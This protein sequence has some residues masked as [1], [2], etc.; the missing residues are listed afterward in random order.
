MIEVIKTSI[1]FEG[2]AAKV[3][4]TLLVDALFDLSVL[5]TSAKTVS[6]ELESNN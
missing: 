2:A 5:A 6:F 1:S 3:N 4:L